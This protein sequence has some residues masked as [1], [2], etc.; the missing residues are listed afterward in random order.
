M[1]QWDVFLDKVNAITVQRH[2]VPWLVAIYGLKYA[3]SI[4][5]ETIKEM[6]TALCPQL[7]FVGFDAVEESRKVQ[8]GFAEISKRVKIA[9]GIIYIFSGQDHILQHA[10]IY[11]SLQIRALTACPDPQNGL[12]PGTEATCWMS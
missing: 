9:A 12:W 2:I 7:D 11:H 1:G 4:K 5:L 10:L 6:V 3:K 8:V